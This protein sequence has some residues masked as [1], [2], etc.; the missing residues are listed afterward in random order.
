MLKFKNMLYENEFDIQHENVFY[1]SNSSDEEE[2][3]F[4][5]KDMRQSLF[6]RIKGYWN[7]FHRSVTKV[8]LHVTIHLQ[9]LTLL[10]PLFYFLYGSKLEESIF[11]SK[12]KTFIRDSITPLQYYM[13]DN[14]QFKNYIL[15]QLSKYNENYLKNYNALHAETEKLNHELFL[16]SLHPFYMIIGLS[17]IIF[18]LTKKYTSISIRLIYLEHLFLMMFVGLYEYWFFVKIVIK[19]RA[20]TDSDMRYLIYKEVLHSIH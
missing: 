6:S 3:L 17:L 9:F 12:I 16:K 5:I 7:R 8:C 10:E 2:P 1:S 19:Y 14:E 4:T 20:A 15:R 18:I 13:T 11:R